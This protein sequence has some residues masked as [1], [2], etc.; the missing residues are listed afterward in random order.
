MFHT[1]RHTAADRGWEDVN[2]THLAQHRDRWRPVV[3]T[4]MNEVCPCDAAPCSAVATV[5]RFRGA[6]RPNLL[7]SIVYLTMLSV[8]RLC[9]IE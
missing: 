6:Y 4:V 9:R 2:W 8:A 7:V 3:S 1:T 5:R